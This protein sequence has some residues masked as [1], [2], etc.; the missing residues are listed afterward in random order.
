[1]QKKKMK[2]WSTEE[3]K[4]KANILV[5]EDT[6]E[7]RK[8]KGASQE[9]MD[10][11]WKNLAGKIQGEVVGKRT[12]ED[13]KREAFKGRGAPLEW[14][15]VRRSKKYRIKTWRENCWARI[16]AMFREYNLQGLQSK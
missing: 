14:R 4:D 8:W 15:R 1:M 7:I 11:C 5:E 3:M 6:E 2:G 9:Q 16:F 12:V 13:S 10:E